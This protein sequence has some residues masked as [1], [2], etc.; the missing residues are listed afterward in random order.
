[1]NA[2]SVVARAEGAQQGGCVNLGR[3]FGYA[4]VQ[5][6]SL[7]ETSAPVHGAGTLDFGR[8]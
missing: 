5:R 6:H 4:Q 1:M 7:P 3:P 2:T 8:T